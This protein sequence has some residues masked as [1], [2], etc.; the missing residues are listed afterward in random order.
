[1]T[2]F[3]AIERVPEAR[4]P[5]GIWFKQIDSAEDYLVLAVRHHFGE[6]TSCRVVVDAN[7]RMEPLVDDVWEAQATQRDI[8]ETAFGQLLL[9]L[10]RHGIRFVCWCGTD[11]RDLPVVRSWEEVDREV[12]SQTA[13][14]PADLFLRFEADA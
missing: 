1:M 9:Q 4:I 5:E 2:Q 13:L 11:F 6:P 8:G 7:G 12:R 14:Q 10:V 3:M